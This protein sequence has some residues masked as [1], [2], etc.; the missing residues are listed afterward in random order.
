MVAILGRGDVNL[1]VRSLQASWSRVSGDVEELDF[2][3]LS[4]KLIGILSGA[5]ERMEGVKRCLNNIRKWTR[6]PHILPVEG[7]LTSVDESVKEMYEGSQVSSVAMLPDPNRVIVDVR[8]EEVLVVV[9]KLAEAVKRYVGHTDWVTP[10]AVSRDGRWMVSG[11]E[12]GAVR[13]WD[14]EC[15]VGIGDPLGGHEGGVLSVAMN[16]D[17]DLIASGS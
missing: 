8:S 9:V 7:C 4:F 6:K 11:S 12:D 17:D 13:R 10:V 5:S 16:E 1:I 3:Q 14:V 2:R 15:G